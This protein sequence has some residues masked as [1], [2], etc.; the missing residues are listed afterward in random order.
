MK[1]AKQSFQ[2]VLQRYGVFE[3]DRYILTSIDTA[4]SAGYTLFAVVYRPCD[5]IRVIDKYNS[6]QIHR[7]A[8]ED[9]L[10]YEPFKQDADGKPLDAIIDWA[11]I[12]KELVKIQKGQGIVI[13]LAANSVVNQKRR[14]DYWENETRWIAGDYLG[15]VE[16]QMSDVRQRMGI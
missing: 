4:D 9:R 5:S 14:P 16:K 13:T 7:F 15:I 12:P 2:T 8:K 11:G 3:A 1:H 6:Q 10:F